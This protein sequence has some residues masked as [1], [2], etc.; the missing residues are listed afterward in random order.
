VKYFIL[1]FVFLT[2]CDWEQFALLNS[3]PIEGKNPPQTVHVFLGVD[4]LS[5]YAL[6]D[7]K[8]DP[9]WNVSRMI[10]MF[11]SVSDASW[12]RLLRSKPVESYEYQYFDKAKDKIVH[13]GY[14]GLIGGHIMPPID[15]SPLDPPAYVFSFDYFGNGYLDTVFKYGNSDQS[16]GESLDNFLFLLGGR[17]QTD[18]VFSGY[19]LEIDA[20]GHMQNRE[21]ALRMIEVLNNRL[22]AF[23]RS[24][25]KQNFVFTIVSD[26]GMDFIPAKANELLQFD[27]MMGG[28]GVRSVETFAEGKKAGGLFAVPIIHTRVSY[29][30]L[31]TL[32]SMRRDVAQKVSNSP[33]TDLVVVPTD[34][35]PTVDSDGLWEWFSIFRG[36]QELLHFAFIRDRD[37]YYLSQDADY[38]ALGLNYPSDDP[39]LILSDEEAFALSVHSNYPDLLF[40]TRTAFEA[41]S[42]SNPADVLISFKR[43]YASL[44][45]QIPFG[46]NVRA[47]AGFHGAMDDL[48]SSG[49]VMTQEQI[50]PDVIR[51]DDMMTFF[52]QWA[53]HLRKQKIVE[54]IKDP[55]LTLD[56][57]KIH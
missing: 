30:A 3:I 33:T 26:H 55:T 23:K 31:H 40:R 5:Y 48:A 14:P 36:G 39:S 4:G 27:K 10:A 45:F 19:F 6:R 42:V 54:D 46:G 52:P 11:P 53:E 41:L 44:G 57:S 9:S 35:D 22:M 56:Y 38:E 2:G 17:A 24:H 25:P 15:G 18:D 28:L 37:A 50:M 8:L 16:S 7:C 49:V 34:P 12:G 20:T 1:L 32:P 29:L 43:P 21:Q 13:A 51:S 47:S